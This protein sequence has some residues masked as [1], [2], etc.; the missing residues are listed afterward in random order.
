MKNVFLLIVSCLLAFTLGECL[1]RLIVCVNAHSFIPAFSFVVKNTPIERGDPVL[2]HS[3]IP[4]R[5]YS[6]TGRPAGFEFLTYGKVNSRGMNY[7]EFS[8]EQIS[9]KRKIIVLG[10]SFVE[11]RQVSHD[12]SFCGIMEKELNKDKDD[13]YAVINAGVSSY[14]PILEYLY[15]KTKLKELTPKV[16]LLV[17]FANDVFD[18]MRY[19]E[20]AKFDETGKPMLVAQGLPWLE[21]VT[22]DLDYITHYRNFIIKGAGSNWFSQR[23]YVAALLQH[24]KF[25]YQLKKSFPEPPQNQEYFI[26]KDEERFKKRQEQGWKLTASYIR[27]LNE[28]VKSINARLVLSYAP[29]ASEVC[30][31][32][33]FYYSPLQGEQNS[34][35]QNMI[36]KIADDNS[37]VYVDLVSELKTGCK[38]LYFPHDGHWTEAGHKF[39]AKKFTEVLAPMIMEK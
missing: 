39:V 35:V 14:S 5:T 36:K 33:N 23:F 7:K 3:L 38:G 9:H 8:T 20:L 28:E 34:N 25:I 30:G 12:N 19:S 37:I 32:S 16:V 2:N 6:A 29:I 24:A 18:D 1:C 17:L 13:L 22:D 11:A 27:M 31:S 21:F 10:D 15:F 26:F 4:N